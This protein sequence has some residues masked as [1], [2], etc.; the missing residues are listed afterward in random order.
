VKTFIFFFAVLLT[1]QISFAQN[2]F[3]A[4]IKNEE[5]K[6]PITGARISVRDAEIS[7]TTNASGKAELTNVPEG[8]QIIEIIA[9]GFEIQQ[10]NLTFPLA[11]QS[12]RIILLKV[13]EVGEVIIST[14]RTGREIDDTPTRVEAIDAE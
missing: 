1:A 3:R 6:Q 8:E 2:A 11:D 12:E 10:L 5:T 13:N 14:T 9:D 7:A 4:T